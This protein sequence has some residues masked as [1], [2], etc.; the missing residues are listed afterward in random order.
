MK[1]GPISKVMGMLPGMS[2][3]M[4]AMG[5][6]VGDEEVRKWVYAKMCASG[7][8]VCI[9][10]PPSHTQRL[11][12]AHTEHPPHQALPLHDGLHDGR[13]AGREGGHREVRVPRLAHRARLRGAPRGGVLNEC[14]IMVWVDGGAISCTHAASWITPLSHHNTA[15]RP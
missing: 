14:I 7:A 1:L 12:Y 8:G 3:M 4:G 9:H 11:I 15:P 2:Q 5:G 6:G 13:G 10:V